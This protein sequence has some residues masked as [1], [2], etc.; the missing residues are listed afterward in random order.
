MPRNK[1][2]KQ[3]VLHDPHGTEMVSWIPAQV[4]QKG[5]RVSLRNTRSEEWTGP[6]LVIEVYG[7]LEGKYAEERVTDYLYQRAVSDV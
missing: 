4:A 5:R 2:Y 7:T 3:C 6:W 1:S